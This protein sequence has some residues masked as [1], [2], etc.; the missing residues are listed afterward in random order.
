MSFVW[1]NLVPTAYGSFENFDVAQELWWPRTH[2]KIYKI[3]ISKTF[4]S[5]Y[6]NFLIHQGNHSVSRTRDEQFAAVKNIGSIYHIPV[7]SVER[8]RYKLATGLRS[9]E[10][11]P[12]RDT[13]GQGFHWFDLSYRV[14]RGDVDVGSLNE[15]AAYYGEPMDRTIP[16]RP[17]VLDG[18]RVRIT[19][20]NQS[21]DFAPQKRS[22]EETIRRD[23]DLAW[24]SLHFRRRSF[25]SVSITQDAVEI[26]HLPA[27]KI[28][29]NALR[30][31]ARRLV[32]KVSLF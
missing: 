8:L 1:K 28:A 3:A 11:L 23:L 29:T 5:K 13:E 9:F 19:T 15:F 30:N 10:T 16:S 25:V 12:K 4:S 17:V 24:D 27:W 20:A 31:R 7:R 6:P 32:R 18:S 22:Y 21:D 2:S 14:R 26:R